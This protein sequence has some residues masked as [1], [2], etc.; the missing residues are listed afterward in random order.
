MVSVVYDANGKRSTT[1]S[2]S[3]KCA[4]PTNCYSANFPPYSVVESESTAV[5]AVATYNIL[6][7]R[8]HGLVDG[9]VGRCSVSTPHTDTAR[10]R[11]I[12]IPGLGSRP[13]RRVEHQYPEYF[14]DKRYIQQSL[15]FFLD[16]RKPRV[17]CASTV[18]ARCLSVHDLGVNTVFF[19][20][21]KL[22][23]RQHIF[24]PQEKSP[25]AQQAWLPPGASS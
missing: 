5:R 22:D 7:Q 3:P 10:T 20:S 16:C 17:S 15:C 9:R 2:S 6:A 25:I 8:P 4:S 12:Y 1:D 19:P 24:W 21:S 18:L 14:F 23:R 11:G 13:S